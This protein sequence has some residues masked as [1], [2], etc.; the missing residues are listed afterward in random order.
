M[1]ELLTY[2]SITGLVNAILS[3]GLALYLTFTSWRVRIAKYLVYLCLAL[4]A[5]STGYF[6]WQISVTES[7]ALFWSRALMMGAIF[8]SISFLHLVIVFLELDK[9]RFYKKLLITLYIPSFFWVF[10]NFTP[11]FVS[12][13]EQKMFF[14]F[15]PTPGFLYHPFLL[16][17]GFQTAYA[18]FL[19]Y[20]AYK[21][22][23]GI[24]KKQTFILL[25]G[26]TLTFI[27]GSTNYFLWYNIPIAPWGNGVASIYAILSVYAIMR[28]QFL[29]VKVVSA[30]IFAGAFL[31]MSVVDALLSGTQPEFIFNSIIILLV[32][33]FGFILVRSV[34]KEVKQKE[35]LAILAKSMEQ[36]NLRLQELDKQ[37]T[38]FLSIA[39]HQLRTPLSILKGYIE[40]IQDGAYG[41]PTA[42]M[43]QILTDMDSS[44][45][46]LVKL[47]DE[48]LDISRIEQGRTKY[49]YE[50]SDI[51]EIVSSVVKELKD[52]ATN[53]GL[54]ISWKVPA[55]KLIVYM[56]LE[57]VRHVVFNFIDNA[58]KYSLKGEILVV[59]EMVEGN[60]VVRVKDT[61]IGFNKVDQ[62][63]FFQK[64]Y[65]GENVKGTNVNG[66]GLGIYVCKKF[67]EMHGGEVWAT[68]KGL[69][70]GAE[71]GFSIPIKAG[72]QKQPSD[73]VEN[74]VLPVIKK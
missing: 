21:K 48:F 33:L 43:I 36:A 60:C 30:E 37:K 5:W 72:K 29:N 63:N 19:L 49:S 64:F 23:V 8:T 54:G 73:E 25:L 28:Y 4:G 41:K 57:K 7:V 68:S 62:A 46:R 11:Y 32:G 16:L 2:F 22:S 42:K 18:S 65:R 45:E 40:L 34:K 39:S 17:F 50:E 6:L 27:G 59:L 67:I 26:I 71:F 20:R 70:K 38:E 1:G 52:R 14:K 24:I 66:T 12:G 61:G 35:E 51:G 55:K 9:K 47:V 10:A 13:V 56:D 44:N 31:V 3:L 69:G 58:I 15:W 53:K 74:Q